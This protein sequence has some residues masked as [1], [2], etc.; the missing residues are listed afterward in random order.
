[1]LL[2][3]PSGVAVVVVVVVVVVVAVVVLVVAVVAVSETNGVQ[4]EA[5]QNL[6]C[7]A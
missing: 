4:Q 1:M 2:F 5:E 7:R 3:H 6:L